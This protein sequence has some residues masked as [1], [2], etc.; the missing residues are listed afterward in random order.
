MLA[1]YEPKI[2][3]EVSLLINHWTILREKRG[4]NKCQSQIIVSQQ[5]SVGNDQQFQK[6][7]PEWKTHGKLW[8]KETI[9]KSF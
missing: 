3:D 7:L 8:K 1:K 6:F 2:I 4:I 9:I 5:Q